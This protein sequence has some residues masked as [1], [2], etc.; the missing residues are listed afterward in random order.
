MGTRFDASALLS[1]GPR[2]WIGA[3]HGLDWDSL[4]RTAER[5]ADFQAVGSCTVDSWA[6][7]RAF[8]TDPR[9]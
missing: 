3:K 8:S 4:R 1:P 5:D 7:M 2:R 6:I 9:P